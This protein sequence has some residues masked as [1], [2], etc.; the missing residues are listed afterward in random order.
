MECPR[1]K[2]INPPTAETCDCGYSFRLGTLVE[3]AQRKRGAGRFDGDS[4]IALGWVL[5]VLGLVIAIK[6]GIGTF[7]FIFFGAYL[8]IQGRR[9]NRKKQ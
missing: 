5:I 1:C 2:I 6:L 7:P 4:L 9:K 8:I 3:G